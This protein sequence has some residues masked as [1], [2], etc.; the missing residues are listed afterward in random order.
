MRK[1]TPDFSAVGALDALCSDAAAAAASMDFVVI[2]QL[3]T[4]R[5]PPLLPSSP[6][7]LMVVVAKEAHCNDDFEG[8]AVNRLSGMD[9]HTLVAA[10]WFAQGLLW[11]SSMAEDS[12]KRSFM[13]FKAAS[14]VRSDWAVHCHGLLTMLCVFLSVTANGIPSCLGRT[15]LHPSTLR[16]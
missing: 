15:A 8:T 2:E 4:G 14:E 6:P 10:F 7:A 16:C 13:S 1:A 3:V 12:N 9:A 11:R 5:P